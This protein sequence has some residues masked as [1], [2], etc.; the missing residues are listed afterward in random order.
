MAAH[1]FP[2]Q[3]LPNAYDRMRK[4]GYYCWDLYKKYLEPDEI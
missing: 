4:D 3:A 1:T 2:N